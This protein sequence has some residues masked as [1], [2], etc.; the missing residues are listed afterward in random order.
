MSWDCCSYCRPGCGM[1]PPPPPP[2]PP[3]QNSYGQPCPPP[4]PPSWQ[5]RPG[6]W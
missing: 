1:Y 3:P 6:C 4:Y 5:C 2:P